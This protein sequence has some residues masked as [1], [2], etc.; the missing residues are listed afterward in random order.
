MQRERHGGIAVFGATC[1][2]FPL[3]TYVDFKTTWG[4]PLDYVRGS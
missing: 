2:R 3:S 1:G 4:N